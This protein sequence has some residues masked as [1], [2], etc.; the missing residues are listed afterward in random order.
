VGANSVSG[1]RAGG[2][3][4]DE[5]IAQTM[6][7]AVFFSKSNCNPSQLALPASHFCGDI[8]RGLLSAAAHAR[9]EAPEVL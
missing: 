1:T 5:V 4:T 2:A 6:A 8:N 7:S 3:A 9:E